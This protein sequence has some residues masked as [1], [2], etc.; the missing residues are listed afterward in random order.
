MVHRD[1]GDFYFRRTDTGTGT[2][3]DGNGDPADLTLVQ[4]DDDLLERTY[5]GLQTLFQYRL[6]DRI[7]IGGNWT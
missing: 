2:V 7:N 1:F 4:N 3:P 6:N 5:D